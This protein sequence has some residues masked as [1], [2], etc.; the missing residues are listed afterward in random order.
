MPASPSSTD[1]D[2]FRRQAIE[3]LRRWNFP[4]GAFFPH[5]S[6]IF[7]SSFRN[8]KITPKLASCQGSK[9][10]VRTMVFKMLAVCKDKFPMAPLAKKK[11]RASRLQIFYDQT[12]PSNLF[13][14]TFVT[15]FVLKPVLATWFLPLCST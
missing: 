5:R 8:L 4:D 12:C 14:L 1:Q 7:R 3:I 2:M 11:M 15:G 9:V 13:V 10:A 6:L